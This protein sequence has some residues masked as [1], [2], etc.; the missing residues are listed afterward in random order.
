MTSRRVASI[1]VGWREFLSLPDLGV[2][3]IKAKIDTGARTSVLHAENVRYVRKGGRR[4][5]RF[6]VLPKQRTEAG[7][8]DAIAPF[9]E[10]RMVRSSNGE[11]ERR[12][13]IQTTLRL[14]D[15]EWPI[16]LTLT[17]RDVMGFRMLLG[18]AALRGRALIDPGHSFLTTPSTKRRLKKK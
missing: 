8:V 11:S 4:M 5:V 17:R 13:V 1:I 18:R 14:R 3:R 6:T 10:E 12:P 2:P 9:I 7:A 16:E 15:D